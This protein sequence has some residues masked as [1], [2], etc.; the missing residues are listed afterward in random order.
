MSHEYDLVGDDPAYLIQDYRFAIFKNNQTVPLGGI[1]HAHT[2][3]VNL[4]TGINSTPLHENID[5]HITD[6][7]QS[8]EGMSA[9][10]QASPEFSNNLVDGISMIKGIS[11]GGYTISVSYQKLNRNFI[12]PDSDPMDS[13]SFTPALL[14]EILRDIQSIKTTHT[15]MRNVT[16]QTLAQMV[17]RPIDITGVATKNS[18]VN[19]AHLIDVPNNVQVIR[20]A[21]GAFYATPLTITVVASGTELVAETDYV[22]SGFDVSRTT[23][24]VSAIGVYNCIVIKTSVVGA[25]SINYQSY[26]GEVTAVDVNMIRNALLDVTGYLTNTDFV[27]NSSLGGTTTIQQLLRRL[28][29]QE[30]EMRRLAITGSPSYGDKTFGMCFK[31]K[32]ETGDTDLHFY[33]IASLYMVDGSNDVITADRAHFRIQGV[34]TG[35]MFDVMVAAN[36]E[37]PNNPFALDVISDLSVRGYLPYVDYAELNNRVLPHF[38]IIWNDVVG[39][40]SGIHLQIGLALHDVTIETMAV[41]DLSG[42][43]SC[44]IMIPEQPTAFAP[45]DDIVTLPDESSIWSAS[46][47]TSKQVHRVCPMKEGFLIWA[48]ALP[49]TEC[50]I[51]ASPPSIATTKN[52]LLKDV[53]RVEFDIFDRKTGSHTR[54]VSNVFSGNDVITDDVMFCAEDLC[55]LRYELSIG[56]DLEVVIKLVSFLQPSSSTNERFDLNHITVFFD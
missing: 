2:I 49:L 4:I 16:A 15:N 31:H 47:A 50:S 12:P 36:I 13:L 37:D 43:E 29:K 24:S 54:T 25:V 51:D 8:V 27:T 40:R 30:A 14:K 52:V 23:A 28:E 41:E 45:A 46:V 18:I 26:G 44:W 1:A 10:L 53:T 34:H 17:N 3:S 7:N 48:G 21:H 35:K 33:T 22:V 19:E 5:W 32:F 11:G 9:A 56:L 6:N 55:S 42:S 39:V 20:P 38:R